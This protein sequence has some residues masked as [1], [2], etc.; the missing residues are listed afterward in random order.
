MKVNDVFV[1]L[2][3]ACLGGYACWYASTLPA[4]RHLAFGPGL[5]PAIV[6][7]G[8]VLVGAAIAVK[9]LPTLRRE[10]WA[11]CPV[12]LRDRRMAARFWSIPAAVPVYL[13][14]ADTLGF[15]L[16]SLLIMVAML[17]VRGVAPGRALGV[18]TGVSLLLT[19]LFASLLKVPLPWGPLTDV[20]GYLLW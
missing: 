14:L 17:R 15:L 9:A 4:P 1:G 8:L 5:F 10:S 19:V 6:G 11:Q 12:W 3:F 20:S 2:F 16:T 7:G 13:L 18:S